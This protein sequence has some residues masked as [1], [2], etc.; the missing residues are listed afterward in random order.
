MHVQVAPAMRG[1]VVKP[2]LLME[3]PSAHV[4][5]AG[6]ARTVLLMSMNVMKVSTLPCLLYRALYSPRA[7]TLSYNYSY[8]P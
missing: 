7:Y 2:P 1:L 3:I 5:E 6:L 8:F 4:R